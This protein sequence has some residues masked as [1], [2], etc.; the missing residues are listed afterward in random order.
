MIVFI[1]LLVN[2]LPPLLSGD[3]SCVYRKPHPSV[4]PRWNR[5]IWRD[6]WAVLLRSGRV[7]IAIQVE[8]AA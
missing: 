2:D 7:G 6:D 5:L 4:M 8:G 3:Y 1:P